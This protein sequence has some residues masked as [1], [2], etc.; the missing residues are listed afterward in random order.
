MQDWMKTGIRGSAGAGL[1]RPRAGLIGRCISLSHRREAHQR[2]GLKRLI[3]MHVKRRAGYESRGL[4]CP[5]GG[6]RSQPGPGQR[7]WLGVK[8]SREEH[9]A[10]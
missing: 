7:R 1:V 9:G 3:T 8:G 2:R 5:M 6:R 4:T 10:T